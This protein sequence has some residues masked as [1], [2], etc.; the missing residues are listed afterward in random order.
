MCER[1][2]KIHLC[3][4]DCTEREL[5]PRREG[6]V[7][8]L[9]QRCVGGAPIVRE[10][11]YTRDP[12]RARTL[13]LRMDRVG[14]PRR[15]RKPSEGELRAKIHGKIADRVVSV[16]ASAERRT[17]YDAELERFTAKVDST[18]RS[19]PKPIDLVTMDEDIRAIMKTFGA[20]LNPPP[21]EFGSALRDAI[22]SIPGAWSGGA[23]FALTARARRSPTL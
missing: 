13:P 7:C 18:V 21:M 22:V 5:T 20:A 3:G 4:D 10:A 19:N 6:Y 15:V 16:F 8:R 11:A 14:G 23:G 2:G 9:T 12:K 1:Y 17:I